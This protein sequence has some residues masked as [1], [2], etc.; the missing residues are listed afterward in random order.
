MASIEIFSSYDELKPKRTEVP[1]SKED[2]LRRE[3]DVNMLAQKISQIK[4]K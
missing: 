2:A 4:S 3:R 1:V